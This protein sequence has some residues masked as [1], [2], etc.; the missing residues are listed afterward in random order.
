MKVSGIDKTLGGLIATAL[1]FCLAIAAMAFLI[2]RMSDADYWTL[3]THQVIE[4]L[5]DSLAALQDVETGERGYVTT[6][7]DEFLEP[8]LAGKENLNFH[9]RRIQ[10][11]T[12]DNPSQ[13]GAI[14]KLKAL[15]QQKLVTS[16]QAI[17]AIKRRSNS[18]DMAALQT[19][20]KVTMDNYRKQMA[21]MIDA[22]TKLLA[23][24]KGLLHT[25]RQWIWV[26]TA[27]LGLF[28]VSLMYWVAKITQ[29]TIEAEKRRVKELDSLNKGLQSEIEQRIRTERVLKETTIKLSGSNVALQQFA[30]VASHDL[31]EPLRAIAGFLTLVASKDKDNLDE[32]SQAWITHAVEGAERMRSLITD[33]L[34]YARVESRGK[35]LQVV[36]S[37]IALKQA[38]IDLSTI[39]AE[40]NARIDAAE[41][42]TVLGDIGQL[43]R[44]FQ[45][46][47]GNSVKFRSNSEPTVQINVNKEGED[48][49]FS[50]KDNGIGFHQKHADR[51][52]SIFQRLHGRDEYEGTGI[53]LAVC[54][55]IV[56][57]HGGRIWAESEKD[58]GAT[59]FFT[60]PIMK[61]DEHAGK[62]S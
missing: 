24:R 4:E 25:I 15:S 35:P 39:L 28:G 31:Q 53:G 8:Y 26:S 18:V 13:Q 32:E 22:E 50:V 19:S 17:D 10:E 5:K 47:I 21:L 16:Q 60:I 20:G 29:A 40:T 62:A 41:L 11:L 38:K 37:N 34:S 56:E 14:D 54:R 49:L 42:P 48:W 23:E 30:Y 51:I 61:G 59:F 3:H 1:V 7:K 52:F 12:G 57:R 27:I 33:L 43:S 2:Y 44:L 45:N 36:D 55:K 58:K 6:H 46:L 9:I